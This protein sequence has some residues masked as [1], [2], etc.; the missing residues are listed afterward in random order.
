[1]GESSLVIIE[2]SVPGI[3]AVGTGEA[4]T[5]ALLTGVRTRVRPRGLDDRNLAHP[6]VPVGVG[7]LPVLLEVLRMLRWRLVVLLGVLTQLLVRDL[8]RVLLLM[9]GRRGWLLQMMRRRVLL[10][11]LRAMLLLELLG[12]L[13]VRRGPCRHH[14]ASV[15]H[16][17][18]L[19][20]M[21]RL[22]HMRRGHHVRR[23]GHVRSLSA[24]GASRAPWL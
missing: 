21:R 13:D 2:L 23:R 5:G 22:Y 7:L 18:G 16:G 8:V 4:I 17:R 15:R 12:L 20:H 24:R 19:G 1:M 10:L 9:M 6:R 14:R 11:E 3:L